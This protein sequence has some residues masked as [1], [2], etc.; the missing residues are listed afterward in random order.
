[1]HARDDDVLA[2]EDLDQVFLWTIDIKCN[3]FDAQVPEGIV[4]FIME[5]CR[6]G[7]SC[8]LLS[9]CMSC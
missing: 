7:Q 2:S 4:A 3:D 1:M 6:A 8:D 5:G 9:G